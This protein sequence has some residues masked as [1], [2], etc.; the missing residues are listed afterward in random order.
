MKTNVNPS[1]DIHTGN[2]EQLPDILLTPRNITGAAKTTNL[3]RPTITW[4]REIIP[5]S[6]LKVHASLPTNHVLKY[7]YVPWFT[8]N[9]K[10]VRKDYPSLYNL[11][12]KKNRER[13]SERTTHPCTKHGTVADATV[14]METFR[15]IFLFLFVV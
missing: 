8:K 11:T 14:L 5:P 15:C 12:Y 9:Q 10:T 6:P 3:S 4:P 7:G 13:P 2:T 1:T